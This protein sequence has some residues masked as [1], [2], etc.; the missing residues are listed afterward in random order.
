MH[1][2]D[3]LEHQPAGSIERPFF[4]AAAAQAILSSGGPWNET[5]VVIEQAIAKFDD[6]VGWRPIAILENGRLSEPYPKEKVRPI[7]LFESGAGV[8]HGRY[9]KLVSGAL[10][11]LF[12]HP[13][14]SWNRQ[15]LISR[16]S[17][18]LRL[19]RELLIFFIQQRV[20]QIISLDCGI[21]RASMVTVTTVASS[22]SRQPL[23]AFSHGRWSAHWS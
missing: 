15:T 7:P 21:R 22:Y 14:A 16:S 19:I 5:G 2:A 17:R 9:A 23:M 18:N 3:L 4:I 8:A 1:H 10:E 12:R 11:I 13:L 20:D 6:Y